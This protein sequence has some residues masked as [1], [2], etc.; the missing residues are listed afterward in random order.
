MVARVLF[1][2]NY[3]FIN[4]SSSIGLNYIKITIIIIIDNNSN[5][6]NNGTWLYSVFP[7][8]GSLSIYIIKHV[9]FFFS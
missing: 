4:G 5:N 7:L 9:R 2:I 6:N 3:E 1:E 8:G